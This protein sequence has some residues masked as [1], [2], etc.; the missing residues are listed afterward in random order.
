MSYRIQHT[1]TAPEPPVTD[2]LPKNRAEEA[3]A[4]K[5]NGSSASEKSKG[6][7]EH[8]FKHALN[9]VID[10]VTPIPGALEAITERM[11]TYVYPGR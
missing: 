10:A 1:V 11:K 8:E 5:Y 7:D 4:N 6:M 3:A 2:W 9:A